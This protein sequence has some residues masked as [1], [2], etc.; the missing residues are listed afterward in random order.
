[1]TASGRLPEAPTG[2]GVEDPRRGRAQRMAGRWELERRRSEKLEQRGYAAAFALVGLI[3]SLAFALIRA[4]ESAATLRGD[5]LALELMASTRFEQK[6]LAASSDLAPAAKVLYAK[7]GS[8]LYVLVQGDAGR[9]HVDVTDGGGVVRD[10]GAPLQRG[11]VA[12]LFV[13]NADTPQQVSLRDANGI[14]AS[15]ALKYEPMH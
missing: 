3:V 9:L 6:A 10:I 11:D 13:P 12:T 7:D 1:M 2:L 8:W 5:E 4:S 14:I 15:A